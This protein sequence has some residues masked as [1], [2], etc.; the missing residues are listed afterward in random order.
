MSIG[1]GVAAL[2]VWA[3]VTAPSVDLDAAQR[4]PLVFATGRRLQPG[5]A[6]QAVEDGLKGLRYREVVGSPSR[7]GEFRRSPGRWEIHL[8]AREDVPRPPRRVR[9]DLRGSRIL[10]VTSL[11]AT[12]DSLPIELEPEL[13]TGVGETGRERR[14]PLAL[15]EMSRFIPAAVLA[16]EDH[17]FFDHGGLDVLAVGRALGVNA[18]RGEIAQGAS[19]LTQQ[20]V[21]NLALG[22]ER[23]WSRK[24]REG[25]L[26]LAVEQRYTKTKILETYLNT[27]YLGQHGRAAILGVGA[28]AQSY[29]GKDAGRLSA[30]ESALLAGMIRAPNRY[31]PT[32]HPERAHQRRDVVLRRMRQL[33]MIDAPTLAAAIAERTQVRLGAEAPSQAPYFLDYVRAATGDLGAGNPRIYTTLDTKLQRAAEVA[34][35]R[36]LDRLESA[37]RRLRR[38]RNGE[39]VQVALVALEPGTGEVR[40]LVGG[41]DYGV[42]PFNR[43]T[44]AR[45]QPGSAFKPFVFL[46]ALRRGPAGQPPVV[47]PASLVEDLPIALET[48]HEV[49]APRNFEDRF[50]GVITVRRALEQSSNAVAVRLARAAGLR[51]V[52]RAARDVGFTSRM[53]PVPALALG[54][55]E[56]TP[57]ELGVAFAT[58]ANGGT[59]VRPH[60]VRT[61]EGRGLRPDIRAG[62]PGVSAEESYLLTHLLR[63]VV[64]RGTAAAVRGFGLRG[65][66]AGKTGTT[67]DTRDAW[68]AG[69]S[70][71]LVA[72]VW[73]GFDDGTPL[74]L[75]GAQAALPIWTDFM[76]AAAALD[77]PGEFSAP[78]TVSFGAI[79]GAQP[80]VL[81]PGKE[82][83]ESCGTSPLTEEPHGPTFA[84][85]NPSD[86]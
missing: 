78:P 32:D 55:F 86:R 33:G 50:E 67:N 38:S 83:E 44:Q 8:R 48:S 15:A 47:T 77:E 49:W 76:R 23:T 79:C 43:V 30:A 17:R 24:V 68:F 73:V 18:L 84:L 5:T 25:A 80:D 62:A 27:V 31:S 14:R 34:I 71:R 53:T 69:Y 45:R 35:A 3:Q 16:A 21:K 54:S 58:L 37:H 74:G 12:A 75:S 85:T 19:T 52:V 10:E 46:A 61:V 41:R 70:P 56:V 59:R 7:P 82:P 63:G 40:A 51:N 81:L 26:A 13:L 36:G 60:G 72:V 29:W 65:A 4:T 2:S 11:S 28:A 1:A 9:L 64:D 57:L 20:L 6:I 39:G 66:V 22:P 42:S